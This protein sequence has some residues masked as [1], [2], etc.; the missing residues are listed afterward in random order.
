VPSTR[1]QR[2]YNV[3]YYARNRE[4]EIA[5]VTERQQATLAWLRELRKVPCMDC[6]GTFPPYVMEFDHRDPATK[7]FALTSSRAMLK[8]RDQLLAEIAKCDIVCSN[9]HQ[10]RTYAAFMAGTIRPASFT[11][12]AVG[13]TQEQ[14][15]CREKWTRTRSEQADLLRAFRQGPCF[16]CGRSSDWFVMEFDHRDASQKRALVPRMAGQVSLRRLL[17][18][19]EKCDIVCSNCHRVRTYVRREAAM[20]QA[21]GCVVVAANDFSKVGVR[22]RFPPPAPD[23]LRLIDESRIPYRFAA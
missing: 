14:R 8:P 12:R 5:R 7:L 21:R 9:C 13:G 16:D 15:R 2:P 6:G 11:Q 18:E 4:A 19:L 22:V 3:A 1:D 23:Q 17:E 10:A 20:V